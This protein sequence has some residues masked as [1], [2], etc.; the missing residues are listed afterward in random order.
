[1]GGDKSS[2]KNDYASQSIHQNKT[3]LTTTQVTKLLFHLLNPVR[4]RPE[5]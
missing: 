2:G 1:M 5:K 3:T 4:G